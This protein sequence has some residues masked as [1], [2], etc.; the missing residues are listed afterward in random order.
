[1]THPQAMWV[2]VAVVESARCA[3]STSCAAASA[4]AAALAA[5]C[6]SANVV[7]NQADGSLTTIEAHTG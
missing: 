2:P 5:A 3:E 6:R 1:M 4:A 7:K